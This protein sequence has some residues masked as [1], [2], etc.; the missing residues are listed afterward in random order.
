MS[1]NSSSGSGGGSSS[2]TSGGNG[3]SSDAAQAGSDRSKRVNNPCA[4][5]SIVIS[6]S[7]VATD[8]VQ[9]ATVRGPLTL[10]AALE[11]EVDILP[12]L[13]ALERTVSFRRNQLEARRSQIED[14]I[15]HHLNIPSTKFSLSPSCEWIYGG[16][17]I[18]LPIDILGAL[19]SRLPRTALIR[20]AMPHAV[21]EA[22]A[23]GMVE[24]KTRCEAA[25][26]TWLERDCPTIPIPRLLGIGSP[27]SRSV[28]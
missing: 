15:S 3:A 11:S 12:T 25:T 27:G 21:G 22:Y 13:T 24:E 2:C 19:P 18:R 14:L 7:Y 16:F 20:F 4:T 23:F 1:S 26:Y 5:Y 17:N 10:K 6:L 28:P 9:I 8:E